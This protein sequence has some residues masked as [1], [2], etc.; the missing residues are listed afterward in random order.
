MEEL[1]QN[2]KALL[3]RGKRRGY[4]TYEEL[5]R[6]LPEEGVSPDRLDLLLMTLD[7]LGINLLD[8]EEVKKQQ[9]AQGDGPLKTQDQG[10]PKAADLVEATPRIDDPVR[11]YLQQMGEIP[12]LTRQEEITLAKR[13]ELSRKRFR[14]KVLESDLTLTGAIEILS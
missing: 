2:I 13:I 3:E 10:S 4:L 5:N 7:D 6:S 14:R 1:E 8:E 12:L 9:E 11:M